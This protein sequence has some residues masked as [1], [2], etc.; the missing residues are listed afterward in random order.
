[1]ISIDEFQEMCDDIAEKMP[2]EFFDGLNGG[3]LLMPEEKPHPGSV[4]GRPLYIMGE[5]RRDY[6]MGRYIVLYYGSFSRVHRHAGRNK[7][8]EYIRK[9]IAHEFR[10]HMESRS[11]TRDLEVEDEI[12]LGR[13]LSDMY[14]DDE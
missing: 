14:E 10:H 3:I 9:T 8:Y 13:Y 2:E 4:P 5:Y 1:M 11:G 12:E 7:I 6:A